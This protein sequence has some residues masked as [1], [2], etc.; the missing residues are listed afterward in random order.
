MFYSRGSAARKHMAMIHEFVLVSRDDYGLRSVSSFYE[1]FKQLRRGTYVEL[2]DS[3]IHYVADS[4]P[5]FKSYNPSTRKAQ[6]GLNFWGVTVIRRRGAQAA[7]DVFEGWAAL[8][9][10]S[11]PT[12]RLT[13]HYYRADNREGYEKLKYDRDSTVRAFR[14]LSRMCRKASESQGRLFVLHFGI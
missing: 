2:H 1:R 4:L 7:A 9:E 12:L 13:G 3:L 11:P 8:F 6:S 5:W 10:E 14:R